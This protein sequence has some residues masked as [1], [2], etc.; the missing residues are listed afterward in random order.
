MPLQL[1]NLVVLEVEVLQVPEPVE[2]PILHDL[3]VGRVEEQHFEL[4]PADESVAG[5]EAEVVPVQVE[6]G[7]VHRYL[8]GQLVGVAP[9]RAVDHVRRPRL[10]VVARAI[11][12]AGHLAVAGVE[13]ATVAQ[14]EAVGVVFAQELGV[15]RLDQRDERVL[16]IVEELAVDALQVHDAGLHPRLILPVDPLQPFHGAVAQVLIVPDVELR[17][18]FV[19]W[20]G[21]DP[22]RVRLQVSYLIPFQLDRGQVGLL[23]EGVTLHLGDLVVVQVEPLHAHRDRVPRDLGQLVL[24]R[25]EY[26]Q[27]QLALDLEVIAQLPYLVRV[28][29]EP[30]QSGRY[31]RVVE[32]SKFVVAHVQPHEVG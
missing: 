23:E 26:A 21:A 14:G 6:A 13:V 2:R 31:H 7:G 18:W 8:L 29:V 10:I 15:G 11:G 16:P 19:G 27:I 3:D 4:L 25:V 32:P 20:D 12:G 9:V 30:L 5:D 22:Q 24:A 17:K 28:Y 1:S